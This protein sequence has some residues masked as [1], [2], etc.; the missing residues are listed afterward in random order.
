MMIGDNL[1]SE[2]EPAR[3]LGMQTFHVNHL[4]PAHSIRHAL[5]AA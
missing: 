5:G 3:E 4:D 1:E 2:I